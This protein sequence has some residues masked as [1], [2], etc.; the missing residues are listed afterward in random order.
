MI[1]CK[2]VSSEL[3]AGLFRFSGWRISAYC[4]PGG[5]GNPPK[6]LQLATILPLLTRKSVS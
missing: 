1:L 4:S 5:W 6:G 3:M 2:I